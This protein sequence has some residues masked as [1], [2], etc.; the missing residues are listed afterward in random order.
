MTNREWLQSLSDDEFAS[1]ISSC[2]SCIAEKSAKCVS[3]NCRSG[4]T[5]W[6]KA[7]YKEPKHPKTLLE[8]KEAKRVHA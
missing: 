5:M 8:M 1:V 4:K 2:R 6:L 3:L 7:E